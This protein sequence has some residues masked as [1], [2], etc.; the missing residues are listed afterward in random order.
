MLEVRT[1][2]GVAAG[3]V[4]AGGVD[5]G[6]LVDDGLI[7]LSGERAVLTLRGRLLADLVTRRLAG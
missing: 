6:R 2:E 1:R 4:D 5:A 7:D 3:G